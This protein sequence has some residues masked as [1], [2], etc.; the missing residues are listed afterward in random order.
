MDVTQGLADGPIDH[1]LI[2]PLR[3]LGSDDF[4]ELIR[5][6]L[7]E[8]GSRVARLRA[9]RDQGDAGMLAGV[10]HT[11]RGTSSAFGATRL[12]E[13]CASIEEASPADTEISISQLVD[14]V[15]REFDRV[16]ATLTEE[17]R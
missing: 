4:H 9:I 17:L 8:A 12:G 13:L 11:L 3:D 7:A 2:A 10:A 1:E 16:R 5:L 15:T 6:F 14:D